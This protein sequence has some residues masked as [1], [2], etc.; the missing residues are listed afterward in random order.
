[1]SPWRRPKK[2]D[3]PNFVKTYNHP[4][5]ICKREGCDKPTRKSTGPTPFKHCS[6]RHNRDD[7][8]DRRNALTKVA[9][10]QEIENGTRKLCEYNGCLEPLPW[11]KKKFCCKAHKQASKYL[12]RRVKVVMK[13]AIKREREALTEG[14]TILLRACG[15]T[16]QEL[17]IHLSERYLSDYKR[18]LPYT[19]SPPDERG[20]PLDL[21]HPDKRKEYHIDHTI[22]IDDHQRLFGSL[23]TEDGKHLTPIGIVCNSLSN[24]RLI[25]GLENYQKHNASGENWRTQPMTDDEIRTVIQQRLKDYELS[26]QSIMSG[27]MNN[28]S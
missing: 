9:V 12:M 6:H 8:N 19:S 14:A 11:N 18:G 26:N 21:C 2:S 22:S 5:A 24:I 10:Q 28:G 23:T 4:P 27:G 16:E 13:A 20:L 7:Y 25:V 1:M 17:E 3:D 15:W